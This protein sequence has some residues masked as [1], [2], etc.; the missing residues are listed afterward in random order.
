[1]RFPHVAL[2]VQ[3]HGPGIIFQPLDPP[4][5]A[6]LRV[7]A[8]TPDPNAANFIL[9]VCAT[10]PQTGAPTFV[11]VP[12]AA[13]VLRERAQHIQLL[14]DEICEKNDWLEKARAEHQ[15]LLDR[16]RSQK[17]ELEERNQWANN[18]D[19][20]LAAARDQIDHFH[21]AKDAEISKLATEYEEKITALERETE[22][23]SRWAMETQQQLDKCVSLLHETEKTLA[24]RTAWAQSLDAEVQQLRARDAIVEASRWVRLGRTFGVGPRAQKK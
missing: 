3:N 15:E 21:A 13:N 5:G 24:E 11:H 8:E 12:S 22:S 10:T 4:T 1:M 2:F 19:T 7:D 6:E 23:Q 18:L 16:F 14:E 9:A 17:H 20:E